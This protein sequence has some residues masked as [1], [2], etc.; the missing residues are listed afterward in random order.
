VVL[1]PLVH[2]DPPTTLRTGSSHAVE[3]V[4][5]QKFVLDMN[6]SFDLKFNRLI[7][8]TTTNERHPESSLVPSGRRA[9]T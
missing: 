6:Q 3:F 7:F 1:C 5:L 2:I 4:A 8:F 9:S